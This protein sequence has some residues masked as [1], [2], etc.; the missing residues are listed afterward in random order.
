[1]T[2][3]NVIHVNATILYDLFG[4]SGLL[5][6]NGLPGG[7]SNTGYPKYGPTQIPG[8][9]PYGPIIP[10]SADTTLESETK[11]FSGAESQNNS[12]RSNSAPVSLNTFSAASSSNSVDQGKYI[13]GR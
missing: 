11:A 13:D 1:M 12:Q 8:L 10:N 7:Y 6:Q 9:N 5:P 3:T 4:P 2:S